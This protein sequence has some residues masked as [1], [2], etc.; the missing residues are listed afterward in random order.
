MS[1]DVSAMRRVGDEAMH[2]TNRKYS[3]GGVFVQLRVLSRG[4]LLAAALVSPA[5]TATI[6]TDVTSGVTRYAPGDWAWY[7]RDFSNSRA[8]PDE[9]ELSAATV[10]NL[11]LLWS[12]ASTGATGNPLVFGGKTY[13][14]DWTGRLYVND[15]E[16]GASVY[17][18]QVSEYPIDSTPFLTQDILYMGD[19]STFLEIADGASLYAVDRKSGRVVWKTLLDEHPKAHIYGS[20]MVVGDVIIIGVAGFELMLAKDD[21]VFRGSVVGLDRTT[22]VEL[23]RMYFTQND[24]TSGAGV[25]VWSTAAVDEARGVF[26]I[27]TGNTY[28]EP[29]S[30]YAD[31]V[32]A[33]DYATGK[34]KWFYQI[35]P[36]DIFSMATPV[37]QDADVGA[38]PNLFAI[39]ARDVVGVG[40]KSGHYTVLD[41]DTG[42]LVWQTKL[43]EG[44][45]LGGVMTSAAHANGRIFVTCNDWDEVEGKGAVDSPESTTAHTAVAYA[46][47]ADTGK[48]VW[49]VRI[50][51]P[52]FGAVTYANGVVYLGDNG[53]HVRALDA[54]TGAELWT[55]KPGGQIGGGFAVSHGK[56]LVPH[57]FKFFFAGGDHMDGGSGLAVYGLP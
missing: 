8:N 19:G 18:A 4:L 25:S 6:D 20:P 46:L 2:Q 9:T 33:I 50:P 36:G 40:D 37:G 29:A 39:G 7:G 57:G 12:V 44:S 28:E 16:T 27:G 1:G 10:K 54:Q 43:V 17:Q 32:A 34:L 26:Y 45:E 21:Y 52:V 11:K 35:T 55:H 31:G 47:A 3:P 48:V 5:C 38:A 53:G 15:L 49:E 23:W 51:Y 14:T 42:K 30:P 13:F 41:R 22:G 56:L 24:A